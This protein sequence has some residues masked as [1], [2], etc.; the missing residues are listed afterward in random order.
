MADESDVLDQVERNIIHIDTVPK[1]W[2]EHIPFYGKRR[3]RARVSRT[4]VMFRKF[5]LPI[6]R[7]GYPPIDPIDWSEQKMTDVVEDVFKWVEVNPNWFQRRLAAIQYWW[8]KKRGRIRE[9]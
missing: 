3:Y 5:T 2:Y 1:R 6:I 4:V 8:A 7:C 9:I